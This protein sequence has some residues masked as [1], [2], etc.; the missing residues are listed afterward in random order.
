MVYEGMAC[1]TRAL[2]EHWNFC[3]RGVNEAWELLGWLASVTYDF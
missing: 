2:L 1:E 3:A